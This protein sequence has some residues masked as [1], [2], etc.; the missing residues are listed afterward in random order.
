MQKPNPQ[1]KFLIFMYIKLM[2]QDPAAMKEFANWPDNVNPLVLFN[3]LPANNEIAKQNAPK[4]NEFTIPSK[5]DKK[6]SPEIT[7]KLEKAWGDM[8]FGIAWR[9]W[10]QPGASLAKAWMNAY[11]IMARK[12]VTQLGKEYPN[13]PGLSH[14]KE[15]AT[16]KRMETK[17][18]I[19]KNPHTAHT[20]KIPFGKHAHYTKI[21]DEAYKAGAAELG[22]ELKKLPAQE[23]NADIDVQKIQLPRMTPEMRNM[24][25]ARHY[26][27][28]A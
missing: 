23:K 9:E 21:G 16:K 17:A 25:L 27:K 7:E 28:A 2:L 18:F 6:L 3:K 15:H 11:D 4:Q 5:D 12:M 10:M 20:M 24:I 13:N 26:G 19:D 22:A 1:E 14:L 8:F